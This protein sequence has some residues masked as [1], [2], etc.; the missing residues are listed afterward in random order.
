MQVSR[1]CWLAFSQRYPC[2]EG[3][4]E[5]GWTV[6]LSPLETAKAFAAPLLEYG[7]SYEAVGILKE[8]GATQM[9]YEGG[10]IM[11]SGG[12]QALLVEAQMSKVQTEEGTKPRV[13]EST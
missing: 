8:A 7:R 12:H 11:D 10:R 6:S 3:G 5:L 13:L 1:L 2:S 4:W 9:R